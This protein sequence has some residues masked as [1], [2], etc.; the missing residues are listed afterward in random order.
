MST[1]ILIA[2][3]LLANRRLASGDCAEPLL[4]NPL[5]ACRALFSN[6]HWLWS[7]RS[8]IPV[9][10]AHRPD[11]I[12]NQLCSESRRDLVSVLLN[13]MAIA[14]AM[15]PAVTSPHEGA[16]LCAASD[17]TAGLTPTITPSQEHG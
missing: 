8:L 17:G 9:A 15:A 6:V 3:T 11:P 1:F 2:N 10:I 16:T 13:L 7:L 5:T 4:P 12:P 14:S